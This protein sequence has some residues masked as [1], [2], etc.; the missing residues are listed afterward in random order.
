MIPN[1]TR[2][3]MLAAGAA[4]LTA[5]CA[6][7]G[8]FRSDPPQ[9]Y[10]LSPKSTFDPGAPTVDWQ[11]L[12]EVPVAAAGLD[13][14]RIALR[15]TATTLDYYADVA[16]T[17]RAP[18]MVQTLLVESFENS[19]N[20]ISIGRQSLGLRADYRLKTELREFQAEYLS[21]GMPTVRVRINA[22]LIRTRS[23]EIIAGLT[24]EDIQRSTDTNM[25]A[26]IF[27]F[28]EALGEVMQEL[29]EWTLIEGQRAWLATDGGA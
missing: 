14:P 23:R 17:D 15:Q 9:L 22:K 1:F 27:A 28:D 29:V 13:S 24:F 26:L 3:T 25:D 5:G 7:T 20:I 21:E 12:V 18:A 4:T 11:L 8:L 2:R 19:G 10:T 6:A 16:W